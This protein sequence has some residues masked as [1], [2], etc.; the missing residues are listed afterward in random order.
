MTTQSPQMSLTELLKIYL[1]NL[2]D[3]GGNKTNLE[4]EVRF[5][6]KKPISRIEFNNVIQ[7][8]ISNDFVAAPP[9]NL[10]RITNEQIDLETGR[11]KISNL[12]R[13][14]ISGIQNIIQYCKTNRL[15]DTL[16]KTVQFVNKDRFI[17]KSE[18]VKP[19]D[20]NNF[21]FRVDCKVENPYLQ[22]SS[23]VQNLIQKWS[24]NKKI[25]RFLN[26][27]TLI[28]SELPFKIDFSIVKSSKQNNKN[29]MIP[30]FTFEDSGILKSSEKFEIEIE[31]DNDKI[32]KGTAFNDVA[33][34][35]ASLRRVIK[36]VLC[37]VQNS[38]YPI[39]YSEQLNVRNNY[40]RLIWGKQFEEHM[41]KR[42]SPRNFMGPS[43]M[44]L[45][46]N[47]IATKSKDSMIPNIRGNYVVTEKTDGERM[48]LYING[49]GRIYL[50]D[51]NMNVSFTGSVVQDNNVKNS[52]FDG[53]YIRYNKEKR[54]VD[55]FAVF[56]AYFIDGNDIR[57]QPF[58]HEIQ[59]EREGSRYQLLTQ[60]ISQ[61]KHVSITKSKSKI[62]IKE[63]QFV[64][65]SKSIFAACNQILSKIERGLF[66]YNTDGL[67]FTPIDL[68]V[69]G[70]KPGQISTRPM[71][72]SW[73][74]SLKW[75]PAHDNTVD[76]LVSI[77][78]DKT[79]KDYKGN[80]FNSGTDVTREN[81]IQQYKTLIL[82]VGYD[83][84]KHG[85]V[86]PCENII[87]DD[88]PDFKGGHVNDYRP[89]QFFPTNPE[90]KK[91]GLTNIHISQSI[92]G[93]DVLLTEN[94]EVIEDNMIVE[95]RYEL[96]N[97]E[98]WRWVPRNVR[99]DKT[100]EFRNGGRNYGNAWHVANSNWNTIH[101]PI[102]DEMIRSGNIPDNSSINDEYY[103]QQKNETNSKGLRH[104]HNRYVKNKLIRSASRPNNTLIDLAVGKAG[105]LQKWTDAKL[106]FVLGI[107]VS[108]DN[109]HNNRDGACS[110]Y[111]TQL[112]R[113]SNVPRAL[114]VVGDSRR[115]ILEGTALLSEKDLQIANA[116][117]GVG[118]RDE[119]LL[120][121]GVYK[122]YGIG[123]GGFDVT[124]IQFAI[125]YMFESISSLLNFLQ[126]VSEVTKKDGVLIGTSFNGNK[127]FNLL[128]DKDVNDSIEF[129]N[130]DKTATILKITKLYDND[131][132]NS[133]YSSIGYPI[134]VYQ[135]SINN[136][137]KEYLVNYELLTR[138]LENY[139]FSP[140]KRGGLNSVGSFKELFE[141]M[142]KESKENSELNKMY[143]TSLEMTS[144][145][146][147]ISNL[148]NYF[149]FQKVRD[150]DAKQVT[151]SLL[152]QGD[153][154]TEQIK[155]Q[156]ELMIESLKL[157]STSSPNVTIK[158]KRKTKL[159]LSE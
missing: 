115:N 137:F 111:L 63:K 1:D 7:Q 11:T 44:T 6:R 102:T 82:M 97:K 107:D 4:L 39:P 108:R 22:S 69:G 154:R 139:G 57:S 92:N 122:N 70:Q 118:P 19:I 33:I 145:E 46:M 147:T 88:L 126:N 8:L 124:S 156:R 2:N 144:S 21:N 74:H 14:E 47:N 90:D 151:K 30:E 65:N 20:F 59:S 72:T 81:S 112:R 140:I 15:P 117:F 28:H 24:D 67:I 104:F 149:M 136:T 103:N 148:N 61:M 146:R 55:N 132:F 120:G 141:K 99:Y 71:K 73:E 84:N 5:G 96:N 110:R 25:F 79:G 131:D 52:L 40:M 31:L 12:V 75:K 143:K 51:T 152:Q 48:L 60:S 41:L 62:H 125:H 23:I 100:Q 45:Q 43:V 155:I 32:G 66:E 76:F 91:A 53:E 133:D 127:I 95:F 64:M 142:K 94:N 29:Y 106:K 37:G 9:E 87:Q 129:H 83:P 80:L 68:G 121:K 157:P 138:L 16:N 116:V 50:I 153:V 56:D 58:T 119:K 109:L 158:Q 101:N 98:Q 26:R 42:I 93:E 77:Q 89:A 10:L 128:K 150:V 134:N 18:I 38:K 35:E 135:E 13:T 159:K 34:L 54:H 49:E 113:E 123:R 17:Y 78:K 105:D 114:F 3:E 130:D 85:Y 27:T 86:N 36:I